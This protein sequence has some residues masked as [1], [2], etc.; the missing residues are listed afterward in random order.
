MDITAISDLHGFFPDLPG[1]DLLIVAGDLTARDLENEY[2]LVD[3]WINDQ[4]YKKKIVIAGNHDNVLAEE[5][6]KFQFCDYLCDSGTEFEGLKIWGSPWTLTFPGINPKCTAFTGDEKLLAEKFA[7]IPDDIDILITHGPP[8]GVKDWNKYGDNC[9]SLS[10]LMKATSL[11]K[12]KLFVF[13]HIHESYG[14]LDTNTR[15]Y[16]IKGSGRLPTPSCKSFPFV[17]NCSHVN[18]RYEPVNK[19]VRIIL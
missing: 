10:L 18:E 9:G 6:F 2:A 11:P 5:R 3:Y 19:P 17:V 15:V 4:P 12:L 16:A 13:G 7:L 14:V 8:H 1:G